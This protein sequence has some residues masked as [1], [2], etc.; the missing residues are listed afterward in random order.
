MTYCSNCGTK[1]DDDAEFCKK[2]GASL[3]GEKKG[4]EKE[5]D[6]KCEEEC[7]GGP[8]GRGWG[9]FWGIIILF[10]GLG[11][12]FELVI[13]KI[14]K[15]DF[16]SSLQWLPDFPYGFIFAILIGIFVI[17]FGLRILGK[18]T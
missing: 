14:P 8:S 2:C 7:Q 5:F 10:I 16:P 11:I 17:I 3:K 15:G 9:I 13:K 6:K 1:N 4:K 18:H 12:I